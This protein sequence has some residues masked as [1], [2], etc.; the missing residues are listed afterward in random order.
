MVV[1]VLESQS[2]QDQLSQNLAAKLG[3]EPLALIALHIQDFLSIMLQNL[4][5]AGFTGPEFVEKGEMMLRSV[6]ASYPLS[7]FLIILHIFQQI[8]ASFVNSSFYRGLC[9][10][11]QICTH[12]DLSGK[13]DIESQ[14][15]NSGNPDLIMFATHLVENLRQYFNQCRKD[16]RIREM[17][18]HQ[19][20]FFLQDAFRDS[21][22]KTVLEHSGYSARLQ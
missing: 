13:H 1:N 10:L 14:Q 8:E 9:T 3:S 12:E 15:V 6:T 21:L 16:T 17:T 4:D 11:R 22:N 18:N 20:M 7:D 2:E 19:I 5:K